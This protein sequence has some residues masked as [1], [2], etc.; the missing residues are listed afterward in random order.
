[1][2]RLQKEGYFR[3]RGTLQQENLDQRISYGQ[4]REAT[5]VP[6]CGPQFSNSMMRTKSGNAGVM[7][8]GARHLPPSQ[9]RAQVGPIPVIFPE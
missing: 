7:H 3:D 9:S 6:I 8:H 1:M 4:H 2:L 5:E